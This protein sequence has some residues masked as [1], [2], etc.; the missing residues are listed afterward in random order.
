MTWKTER[1]DKETSSSGKKRQY[2]IPASLVRRHA[3]R[4][5]VKVPEP[6]F[7]PRDL[8]IH[9]LAIPSDYL[10]GSQARQGWSRRTKRARDAGGDDETSREGAFRKIKCLL[11]LWINSREDFCGVLC[12]KVVQNVM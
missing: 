3:R 10:T 7:G 8:V 6:G 2:I 9:D 11:P 4:F 1:E 12:W 5:V